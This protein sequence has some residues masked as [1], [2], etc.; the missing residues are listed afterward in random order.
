M[1]QAAQD[2]SV[3]ICA[4]TED[5]LNELIA[6]VESV[7]QQI[8]PPREIIVVIDHNPD[9]MKRCREEVPGVLVIENGEA[10]G[11]SGA[12]NSGA[13][14]AKGEVVAFLDD[15]A[16]AE[17]D[18]IEQLCAWY[19]NP[20]VVGVGGKIEPLWLQTHPSW[21]PNEFNWVVGCTYQGMPAESTRVR[22]VT[23]ANMSVRRHVLM[24]CRWLPEIFGWNHEHTGE[25]SVGIHRSGSSIMLETRRRS[26][27]FVPQSSGQ[28]ACGYTYPLRLSGIVF[29]HNGHAYH[30]FCGAATTKAWVRQCWLG[31]MACT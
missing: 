8:L 15:D 28:I 30:T 20:Q 29:R 1:T 31:Y 10:K 26:S 27:A 17:P 16:I 21:F 11:L 6:A 13:S 25:S 23:G 2:I 19:D 22:N 9:L 5:R 12:R 3:I 4:Y 18:W 24:A 7:Q 14:I